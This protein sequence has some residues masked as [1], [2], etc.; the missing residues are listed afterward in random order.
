METAVL[1]GCGL[2]HPTPALAAAAAV[3]VDGATRMWA[4]LQNWLVT[5]WLRY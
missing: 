5:R 1:R 2:A 3:G 4:R